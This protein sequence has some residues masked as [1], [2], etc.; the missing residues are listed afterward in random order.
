MKT[1]KHMVEVL[2]RAFFHSYFTKAS[3]V[4]SIDITMVQPITIKQILVKNIDNIAGDFNIKIARAF[5]MINEVKVSEKLA[6]PKSFAG[7]TALIKHTLGGDKELYEF[8]VER[9]KYHFTQALSGTVEKIDIVN[10]TLLYE[11]MRCMK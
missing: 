5:A 2:V 1:D 3:G 10:D 9:Y 8:M 7:A 4:T 11:A 6:N